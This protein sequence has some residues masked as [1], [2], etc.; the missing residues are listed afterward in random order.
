VVHTL[1]VSND[2]AAEGRGNILGLP[3]DY[4]ATC[5]AAWNGIVVLGHLSGR[6]SIVE[7]KEGVKAYIGTVYTEDTRK[8]VATI[9]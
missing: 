8:P 6:I 9:D 3:P 2:W 1:F 5:V 4:R 7:F